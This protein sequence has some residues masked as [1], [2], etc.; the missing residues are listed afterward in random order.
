VLRAWRNNLIASLGT[1]ATGSV[2]CDGYLCTIVVQWDDTRATGGS[3][4]QTLRTQVQL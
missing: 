2:A 1:A 3:A 4:T